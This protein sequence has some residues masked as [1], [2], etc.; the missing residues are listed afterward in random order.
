ML[1]ESVVQEGEIK[2]P[3]LLEELIDDASHD[4]TC[5]FQA[6][7]WSGVHATEEIQRDSNLKILQILS[8]HRTEVGQRRSRVHFRFHAVYD[9]YVRAACLE[10]LLKSWLSHQPSCS[11]LAVGIH[12]LAVRNRQVNIIANALIIDLQELL[13]LHYA[14]DRLDNNDWSLRLLYL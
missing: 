2:V 1:A 12:R 8:Q 3:S 11:L 14:D 5:S 9:E 7:S 10:P 4:T 6:V 13:E